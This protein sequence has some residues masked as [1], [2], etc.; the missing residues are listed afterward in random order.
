M[1]L[2]IILN[3]A[4]LIGHF[5]FNLNFAHFVVVAAATTVVDA[6]VV[7]VS[8]VVGSFSIVNVVIRTNVTRPTLLN[9]LLL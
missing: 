6:V 7:V 2:S 1:V 4:A 5:S 9:S 3:S 8:F